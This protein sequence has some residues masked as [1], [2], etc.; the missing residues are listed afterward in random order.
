M[1]NKMK[2]VNYIMAMFLLLIAISCKPK[3]VSDDS[4][5]KLAELKDQ[6]AAIEAKI[7][8]LQQELVSKGVIEKSLAKVALTELKTEP[9]YHFID[10]QGRVDADENVA[11]ASKIPGALKKI[12]VKNGDVVRQGQ[13]L[14]EIEDAVILSSL[15]ELKGQLQVAEDLYK[16][17]KSLWD[18]NIGS[19]IQYIQAKNNKESLERSL[20]TLNANWAMTKIYAPTSGT[21]DNVILNQGEAISPGIPL[22][23]IINLS[24]LKIKGEVTEAYA[25]K[26][27]KG[28]QVKVYFPDTEKEINTTINYVSKSINTVSRTFAVETV[29]LKGDYRANQIAVMKI[30]DYQNPKAIIIP[31]NL[32]QSSPE[33][34]Y[35]LVAEKTGTADQATIKKVTV[36]QGQNYSGFVEI[37][38]GLK[39]GDLVV[40]TGFQDI[41]NGETVLF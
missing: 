26:V 1:K 8:T 14:A 3:A 34:D 7:A 22:C 2:T 37:L 33:G 31:V 19:E 32:I 17:Q 16:R 35:V 11:A 24:K 23:L 5:A 13:L 27:N 25:S 4:M 12:Y 21:V 40:S 6:K 41:N 29:P 28:D 38:S 30:I 9:F 36:K 10:L 39:A 18:Q 20:A 15:N